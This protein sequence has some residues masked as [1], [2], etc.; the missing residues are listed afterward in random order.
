MPNLDRMFRSIPDPY[1]IPKPDPTRHYRWLSDDPKRLGMWL[2]SFGDVPGYRLEAGPTL[3]DTVAIAEKLG[4]NDSY[5]D[6]LKNRITFGYNVLASIPIEEHDLRVR[7]RVEDQMEQLAAAEDQMFAK[8]DNIK[9][10]RARKDAV[11]NF[12]DEK[13]FHTREDRPF[14]GQAG[15]G[16]SP[17]LRRRPSA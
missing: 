4:Y 13:R 11:E 3:A 10:V 12:Q 2:R 7:Y 6:K 14:S 5:V 8:F 1:F 15:S 17:A 9:G 16:V